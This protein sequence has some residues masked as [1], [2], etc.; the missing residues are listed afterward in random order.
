MSSDKTAPI[1]HRT[2]RIPIRV[3]PAQKAVLAKAAG[4]SALDVSSWLRAL[5]MERAALLGIT[6]ASVAVPEK[7]EAVV[8]KGKGP[9]PATAPARKGKTPAR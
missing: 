9:K 1:D 2:D 5:G 8:V 3:T 6:E 4:L 7:P